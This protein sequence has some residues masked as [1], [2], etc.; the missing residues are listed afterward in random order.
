MSNIGYPQTGLTVDEFY[1]KSFKESD[2]GERRRL[3]ADAR[4]SN[5]CTY[6]LYVVAAEAEEHWKS[7]TGRIKA[8]LSRGVTVFKNPA[9]QGA[10]CPK[11]SS[12]AWKQE[13][14]D[15]ERRGHPKT[16]TAL[17]EVVAQNC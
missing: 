7:D 3:F 13:A 10:H 4:Q 9:G 12:D 8:I 11:V 17:R 1:S 6:Q 15:A 16:A 2:A 5:L 14:N